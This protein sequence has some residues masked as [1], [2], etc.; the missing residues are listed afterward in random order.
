LIIN[1]A[2]QISDS[3]LYNSHLIINSQ[4]DIVAVY[5]KLHLYDVNYPEENIKMQESDTAQQG[6]GLVPPLESPIGK[7]GMAIVS[8]LINI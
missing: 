7:I 2:F 1:S 8:F 4:G 6:E 3:K 5:R